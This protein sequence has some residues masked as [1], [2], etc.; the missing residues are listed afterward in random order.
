MPKALIYWYGTVFVFAGYI[1][2]N[3]ILEITE[4]KIFCVDGKGSV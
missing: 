3:C 1:T 4:V 2:D